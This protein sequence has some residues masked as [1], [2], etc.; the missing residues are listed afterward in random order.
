MA[1]NVYPA[2]EGISYDFQTP[3]VSYGWYLSTSG[4]GI[5][6][7]PFVTEA[8]RDAFEAAVKARFLSKPECDDQACLIYAACIV[9]NR[10]SEYWADEIIAES[11][12]GRYDNYYDW[13]DLIDQ[14]NE[15]HPRPNGDLNG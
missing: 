15:Q 3:S 14:C 13:S 10:D 12:C 7:S 5:L 2:F 4:D 8:G 9:A 11:P 1:T 6:C